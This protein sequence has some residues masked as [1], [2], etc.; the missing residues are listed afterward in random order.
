MGR[1]ASFQIRSQS[2]SST[3]NAWTRTAR[4]LF[5]RARHMRTQVLGD[6]LRIPPGLGEHGDVPGVLGIL[7]Q[8]EDGMIPERGDDELHRGSGRAHVEAVP[9][10]M[11]VHRMR[12][13]DR[14]RRAHRDRRSESAAEGSQSQTRYPPLANTSLASGGG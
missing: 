14:M 6:P 1:H 7:L 13:V 9:A 2:S 8:T 3:V 10:A 4:G 12:P 11:R 5:A